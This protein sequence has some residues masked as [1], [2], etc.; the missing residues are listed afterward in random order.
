MILKYTIYG[1]RHSG[2]NL[3]DRFIRSYFDLDFNY[4]FGHKHFFQLSNLV[5]KDT[6]DTIF[7]CI[8]RNPY[9][10]LWAM[11]SLPHHCGFRHKN[12][13]EFFSKEWWSRHEF[14]GPEIIEDR[15]WITGEK[16]KNIFE[17]RQHKLCF[18]SYMPQLVKN[19][20]ILNYEDFLWKPQHD[21]AKS[22]SIHTR[23]PIKENSQPVDL[24]KIK[25]HHKKNNIHL[26][27]DINC[28]IDW[29]IESVF[30][31]VQFETYREYVRKYSCIDSSTRSLYDRVEVQNANTTT[32]HTHEYFTYQGQSY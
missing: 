32:K 30:G 7:F 21:I 20:Y 2:T 9:D 11:H 17:L 8:V 28:L 5:D 13:E 31:Y 22:I 15:N 4:S 6:S 16:Y 24:H 27:Y 1:E 25:K 12:I 14:L 29:S 23:I 18:L 10:W 26:L 3:L 19:V